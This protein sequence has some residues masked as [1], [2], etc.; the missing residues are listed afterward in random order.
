MAAP[1]TAITA[2]PSET[3]AS[4]LTKLVLKNRQRIEHPLEKL[5]SLVRKK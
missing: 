2:P 5:E 1:T 3:A 4:D